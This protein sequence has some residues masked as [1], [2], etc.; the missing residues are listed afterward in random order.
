MFVHSTLFNYLMYSPTHLF[1]ILHFILESSFALSFLIICVIWL[2]II[3]YRLCSIRAKYYSNEYGA[4]TQLLYNIQTIQFREKLLLVIVILEILSFTSYTLITHEFYLHIYTP[5][6]NSTFEYFHCNVALIIGYSYLHPPVVLYFILLA[7]MIISQ[8][9]LLAYLNSYLAVRYLGYSLHY[10]VKYKYICLWIFQCLVQT[11]FIIPQL[12]LFFQ[13]IVTILFI[14]SWLNLLIS[15]RKVTRAIRSKMEEI[16]L[17]EWNPAHYRNY[18]RSLKYYKLSIFF[19]ISA[20]LCLIAAL[21]IVTLLL[22]MQILFV[23][24]C[25]LEK[26]WGIRVQFNLTQSQNMQFNSIFNELR[27]WISLSLCILFGTLYIIPSA[28]LFLGYILNGLYHRC[29]GRGDTLRFTYSL[30]EPLINFK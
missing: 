3:I 12:Q 16:R 21:T 24:N 19:V 30:L 27:D 4:D 13:L 26:V 15:S 17:F 6:L 2:F 10:S 1:I 28:T 11:I 20:Y 8:I 23:D 25:Y 14:S 5:G 22:Y 9:M 29:T 7:M 18:A